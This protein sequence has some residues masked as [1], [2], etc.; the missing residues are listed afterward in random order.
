MILICYGT[1]PEYLKLKPLLEKMSGKILYKTLFTGQH[2]N[3]V[4]QDSDYMIGIEAG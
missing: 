1:R 3:L 4:N 2:I